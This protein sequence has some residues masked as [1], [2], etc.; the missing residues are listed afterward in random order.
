VPVGGKGLVASEG[1]FVQSIGVNTTASAEPGADYVGA[2]PACYVI[3][4]DGGAT[5]DGF[6]T[7][8]LAYPDLCHLECA[9]PGDWEADWENCH[10]SRTCGAIGAMKTD[11]E[12][13]RPYARHY[14]GVNIGFLDGHAQWMPSETVIDEAPS[15]GNPSRGR[16]RGFSP[17]GPTR[18]APSYNPGGGIP[19]LY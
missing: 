18:D 11:P 4:A 5:T 8:T 7:G 1:T 14:G 19:A 15:H 17:W 6:C 2:D 10:W 12:L 3:C 9:G 16:L 13:R